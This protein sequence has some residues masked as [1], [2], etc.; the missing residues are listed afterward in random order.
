MSLNLREKSP[1]S[2]RYC[3]QMT[4]GTHSFKYL[5]YGLLVCVLVL[6]FLLRLRMLSIPLERDEGEYA[7]LAQLLLQG[8]PPY[9]HGYSMKFPGIFGC[10]AV[11]MGLF[12]QTPE[13]VHFGLLL[14]DLSSSIL[15]FLLARH[16]FD[17]TVGMTAATC[18]FFMSMSPS[19]L[20]TAAHATHFIVPFIL[21]SSLIT[22]QS[23][24]RRMLPT[25][26]AGLSTGMA[27]L[28][29]QHAVFFMPLVLWCIFVS[30]PLNDNQQWTNVPK[31]LMI[32]TLGALA[33][34][35]IVCSL[36]Y[37]DGVFEKFWFWTISYAR[38]YVIEV[39][40]L[41]GIENFI[42][43][44]FIVMK[45]LILLWV[46]AGFGI[47]L[48]VVRR[49]RF[50]SRFILVFTICA[51]LAIC[52]GFYFR[53]HYYILLLPPLSL[54][55]GVAVASLSDRSLWIKL[56][57][58]AMA[59]AYPF[60]T[61]AD[62]FFKWSP[63]EI[64]RN[65]YGLNPFGESIAIAEF[66]RQ[67][68][69]SDEKIAILGSEPQIYFYS[70]RISATG[71]IY[72]YGLMENQ[73]FSKR[74]QSELINDIESSNPSIIVLARGLDS[75]CIGENSDKTILQWI[76][77]YLRKHYDKAG[78]VSIGFPTLYYWGNDISK[79]RPTLTSDYL[80]IYKRKQSVSPNNLASSN[81]SPI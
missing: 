12:G 53:Q 55:A 14:V 48:S 20:G 46:L 78:I 67:N 6:T 9:L 32:F 57:I 74:M 21:A 76:P 79:Y 63:A 36:L 38:Q 10:Y 71:H 23:T 1:L 81:P 5:Y 28:L 75:W 11:I 70:G 31:Q 56:T 59:L 16:L 30:N 24:S 73:P 42:E 44:S 7:Y 26:T 61:N 41:Q 22:L 52:P 37:Q 45:P 69:R 80:I 15:L 43:Q 54:A 49:N 64:S 25:F 60:L 72:M 8:V 77:V 40:L 27:I 2:E 68:S 33:P 18:F 39:P 3:K 66:I 29:K 51:L 50:P 13:A 19:V 58:P 47:Y 35:A 65:I 34:F 17:A 62:H 4:A